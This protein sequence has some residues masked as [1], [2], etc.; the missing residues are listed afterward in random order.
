MPRTTVKVFFHRTKFIAVDLSYFCNRQFWAVMW[1]LVWEKPESAKMGCDILK[2]HRTCSFQVSR[3][4]PGDGLDKLADL[5]T[6]QNIQGSTSSQL[7][8]RKLVFV[9][10]FFFAI[11]G[12]ASENRHKKPSSG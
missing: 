9:F 4:E 10:F 3:A 8:P 6:W 1:I 11:V 7:F 2:E 5:H 12:F